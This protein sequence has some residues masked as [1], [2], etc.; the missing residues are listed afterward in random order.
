[1]ARL[2]RSFVNEHRRERG[3]KGSSVFSLLRRREGIRDAIRRRRDATLAPA[4]PLVALVAALACSVEA[5][6]FAPAGAAVGRQSAVQMSTQFTDPFV[7]KMKKKN[8]MTGSTKNL[9]GYTVGSRAPK[10]SVSS[11]TKTFGYKSDGDLRGV[12]KNTQNVPTAA[13]LGVPIL[14]YSGIQFLGGVWG[15]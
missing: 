10:V 9:K 14:L 2:P 3:G 7:Q 13:V 5:F 12:D 15:A 1:M 4:P 8:P 11:G 6:S